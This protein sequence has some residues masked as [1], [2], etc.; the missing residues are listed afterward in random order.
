M[1]KHMLWEWQ[2]TQKIFML[3]FLD[4]ATTIIRYVLSLLLSLNTVKHI[5][6]MAG[7]NV[8]ISPVQLL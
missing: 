5:C 2:F 4:Y 8:R 3:E 6:N 7:Q 1:S